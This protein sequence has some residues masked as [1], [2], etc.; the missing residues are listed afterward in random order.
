LLHFNAD[1]VQCSNDGGCLSFTAQAE[2]S[3]A[4]SAAD[5]STPRRRRIVVMAPITA[6]KVALWDLESKLQS[7][8]YK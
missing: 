7:Q 3:L 5:G 8:A 1:Q 6:V 4:W 2:S